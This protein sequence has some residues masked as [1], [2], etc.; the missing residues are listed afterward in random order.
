MDVTLISD[1]AALEDVE[2]LINQTWEN[3]TSEISLGVLRAFSKSG[4]LVS[5]AYLGGTLVGACV[6]FFGGQE[7]PHLHSHLAA[8][9]PQQRAKGIGFAL[10]LHQRAWALS[11][12]ISW[13]SWTFDPLV[14]RNARLNLARLGAAP[15][16]YLPDFYGTRDDAL[17]VSVPTDR[18]LVLWHLDDPKTRLACSRGAGRLQAVDLTRDGGRILVAPGRGDEPVTAPDNGEVTV[19]VG[20]PEDITALRR[21]RPEVA[22]RWR[23]AVRESLGRALDRGVPV[24][25][26]TEQGH[27]VIDRRPAE[28]PSTAVVR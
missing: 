21:D 28:M 8:V 19:L 20:L 18:I 9:C 23:V 12:G 16:E 10:K 6:A 4:N 2:Q 22:E 5:G 7:D 13:V 24:V 11:R 14:R 17:N 3:P 27:Y 26:F 15:V 25:G 1:L